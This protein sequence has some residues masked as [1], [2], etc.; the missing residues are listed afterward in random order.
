[1]RG[2]NL[3]QRSA[4]TST[5]VLFLGGNKLAIT[6]RAQ[7]VSVTL[8]SETFDCYLTRSLAKLMDIYHV[9]IHMLCDILTFHTDH[10]LSGIC[11]VCSRLPISYIEFISLLK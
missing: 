4:A 5:I 11:I 7:Y 10:M 8:C 1:M 3:T 2:T 6:S 9:P